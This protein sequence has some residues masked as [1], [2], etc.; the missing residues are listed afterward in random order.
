[1]RTN[2]SNQSLTLAEA[3]ERTP[4][5]NPVEAMRRQLALA[6][7]D[8]VKPADVVAL[9]EKLKQQAMA[10]DTRAAKLFFE[11]VIGKDK[12]GP[13]PGAERANNQVAEALRD[14]VDEIR[15]AKA[16]KTKRDSDPR[17]THARNGKDDDE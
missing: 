10:G 17:L 3:R 16:D 2:G 6:L 9:A 14:L 8:A 11:L 13:A 12:P 7:Y 1:M 4:A 15:I 5:V